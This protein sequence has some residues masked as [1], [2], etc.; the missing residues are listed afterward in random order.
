[1]ETKTKSKTKLRSRYGFELQKKD[2]ET[3][4]G[5]S[6]TVPDDSYSVRELLDRHQKGLAFGIQRLGQFDD[7]DD[8]DFDALD[9]NDLQ[10]QEMYEKS[11]IM[12]EAKETLRK[13]KEKKGT[14]KADNQ[15]VKKPLGED[16]TK[17]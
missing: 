17:V 5:V 10:N 7:I 6:V 12:E 8:E 15:E 2:M 16:Q 9:M 11:E 1:M 4:K 3:P 14:K 13:V